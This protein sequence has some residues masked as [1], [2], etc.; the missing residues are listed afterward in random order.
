[1]IKAKYKIGDIVTVKEKTFRIDERDKT[2]KTH[3]IASVN[4]SFDVIID[5]VK[6]TKHIDKGIITNQIEYGALYNEHWVFNERD[7]VAKTG[8][9]SKITK[10]SYYNNY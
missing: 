8:F 2:N 7:I 5:M 9:N 1:M 10:P 4:V 3:K 6:I